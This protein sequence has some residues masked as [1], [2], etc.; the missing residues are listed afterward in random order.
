VDGSRARNE[1]GFAP[2]TDFPTG[3]ARTLEW[4]LANRAEA[5]ARSV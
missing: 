2:A 5:E 3:L 4:Y 1:F